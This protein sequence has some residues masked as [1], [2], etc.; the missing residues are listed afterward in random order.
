MPPLQVLFSLNFLLRLPHHGIVL[1]DGR[2]PFLGWHVHQWLP[3]G[4]DVRGYR[5]DGLAKLSE[6]DLGV[7]I[8]IEAPDDGNQLGLQRLM[9]HASEEHPDAAL[10][11]IVESLLI[12]RLKGPPDAE[13]KRAFQF[14]L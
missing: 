7:A 10:G 13:V 4:Q 6:R 5:L 3:D 12:N 9:A 2:H 1:P 8:E 14:L 11:Q